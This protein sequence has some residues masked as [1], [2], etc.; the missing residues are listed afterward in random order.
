[1]PG[2][3]GVAAAALFAGRAPDRAGKIDLLRRELGPAGQAQFA[4]MAEVGENPAR[5]IRA[6]REFVAAHDGARQLYGIGEPAY[7]GRSPAEYVDLF[8]IHWPLP[9][10]T[11]ATTSPP[12]RRCSAPTSRRSAR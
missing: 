10:A 3:G 9:P 6:W 8:L 2:T 12:G 5:I 1:M 7:A 4:D 11:T